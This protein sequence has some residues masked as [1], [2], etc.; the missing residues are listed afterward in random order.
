MS[1][2]EVFRHEGR[3]LGLKEGLEKGLEKGKLERS[4]E[5]AR[6]MLRKSMPLTTIAE[7]TG[8]SR[9]KLSA[10]RKKK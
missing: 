4:M 10:L 3:Q 6:G 1:F 2:S 9:H 8:L 5:I 7:L